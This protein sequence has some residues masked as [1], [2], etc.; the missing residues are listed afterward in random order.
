MRSCHFP[1]FFG[2][3][4]RSVLK[5]SR[6]TEA[7]KTLVTDHKLMFVWNRWNNVKSLI[8]HL[9]WILCIYLF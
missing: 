1:A 9:F 3:I 2:A 7:K 4:W 8:L 6:E 5:L